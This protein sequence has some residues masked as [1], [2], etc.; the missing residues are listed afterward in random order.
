MWDRQHGG[1]FWLMTRDGDPLAGETKHAHSGAYAVQAL[2]AVYAATGE[3]GALTL[4]REGLEWFRKHARDGDHGGFHSW[5]SRDGTVLRDAGQ[6]PAGMTVDPLGHAIGLK[7]VNVHGDWFEAFLELR[8]ALAG[9]S[10]ADGW[11]AEFGQIYMAKVTTPGGEIHYS[12]HPDW[13]P[14]PGLE[15]YGYAFQAAHRMVAAAPALPGL[16]LLERAGALVRH[17]IE[18]AAVPGGGFVFAG[19]GDLEYLLEGSDVRVQ[20][21]SWWVQW[22]AL[23]AL[24]ALP[25][26]LSGLDVRG[27][28]R[29]QW[30]FIRRSM[31]DERF[32]GAYPTCPTDLAFWRRPYGALG[33][34]WGLRKGGEW[35]D[36]S[37]ETDTLLAFMAATEG[38]PAGRQPPLPAAS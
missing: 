37:H 7:D 8:G 19:P 30:R 26:G 1:W 2:A 14:Q 6:A 32:G 38:T 23:R 33:N 11:L 34:A 5:L 20:R 36:A 4:A 3:D 25:E 27:L 13:T 16:A 28:A 35:K 17:A 9:K 12:F 21:R 22:E 29:A 31:L 15:R 10:E 24:C 18:R